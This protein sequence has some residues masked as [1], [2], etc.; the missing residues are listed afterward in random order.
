MVIVNRLQEP[1]AIHWHGIE[2]ESYSD[3]VAGW[4]GAGQSLAPS[5]QPGDSFTAQLILPRAGTFIYHTHMNDVE[6][7][8]SGLY[9]AIVVLEPGKPFDPSTDHVYVAG[10]DGPSEKPDVVINGDSTAIPLSIRVGAVQ[11]FRFV[12]IGAAA[13]VRFTISRDTTVVVWRALAKDGADLPASQARTKPS[14]QFVQVGET[15]DFEFTPDSGEYRLVAV[16][17][18]TGQQVFQQRLVAGE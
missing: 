18:G 13:G 14:T 16:V 17:Q 5:I 11:R 2:L 12:N 9:G 10:W 1:A 15:Y 8:T 7:L 6:Q 3:G 4:S